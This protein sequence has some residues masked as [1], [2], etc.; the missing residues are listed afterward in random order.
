MSILKEKQTILIVDDTPENIDVLKGLLKTDY[1][2]K[3]SRD[4]ENALDICRSK[5][6]PDIILLDVM[7]PGLDGYEVCKILKLDESTQK[8]P[9]IFLTALSDET[10]E[11]TG[12][13]LGAVD[14]I[15]KPFNPDLVKARVRNQL[16]LKLYRDKLEDLVEERTK[17]LALTQEATIE[18]MGTLAEYR[19]PETGGHINRTQHY[20]RVVASHLQNNPKYRDIL[21]KEYIDLLFKSAPLHDIGKVGVRDSILLKPG[22]LT[23]E[24]FEEMKKHTIFGRDAVATVEKKFGNNSF[25]QL[26]REIAYSHHEK[27]SGAGYPQGLSG[28]DI[29]LSGRLMAVADVYDALISKRVYKPPFPHKKAVKIIFEERGKHFD[30][31]IVDA[32]EELEEKFRSIALEYAD[33][34]EEREILLKDDE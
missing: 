11:S 34:E 7:M 2:V 1:K 19:D 26:A 31:A 23:T 20:V 17:E 27:W 6:P 13:N 4:G 30:P 25:L 16:D 15:I 14:Y 33:F 8:I 29:P 28:E 10:N 3:V 18:S 9:V 22:K 21:T 12:L 5:N 24:E 32:F